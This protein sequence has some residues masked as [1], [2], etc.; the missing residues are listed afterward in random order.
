MED[1]EYL[2]CMSLKEEQGML[3]N[4]VIGQLCALRFRHLDIF[5][6]HVNCLLNSEMGVQFFR[7]YEYICIEV[8]Y[9]N[10][11]GLLYYKNSRMIIR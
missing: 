10:R 3:V 8:K 2:W 7:P 5:F 6:Q 4:I 11:S 9:I 1:S